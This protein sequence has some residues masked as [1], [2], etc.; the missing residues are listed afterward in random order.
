MANKR[1]ETHPIWIP[2]V[3]VGGIFL[4]LAII[5]AFYPA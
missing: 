1:E 2:W 5:F 4:V 3:V